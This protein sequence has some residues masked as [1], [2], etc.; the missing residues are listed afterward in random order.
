MVGVIFS[1][2][3]SFAAHVDSLIR[4]GNASLQTLSKIRHL[5][6]DVKSLLH[7]YL[8]YVR[9]VPEYACPVWG[10]LGLHTAHLMY[11]LESVQKRAVRFIQGSRDIPY[12]EKLITLNIQCLEQRLSELIVRFGKAL[13]LDPAH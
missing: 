2:D 11:D 10:P 13:L 1:R 6:C 7:A 12:Q 3:C 8:S 9:P 4:N 5:G